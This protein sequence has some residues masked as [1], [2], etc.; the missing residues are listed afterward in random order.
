MIAESAFE[1]HEHQERAPDLRPS[2]DCGGPGSTRRN[3]ATG[4]VTEHVPEPQESRSV[5]GQISGHH[6]PTTSRCTATVL[7]IDLA[8]A[9][10]HPPPGAAR[11]GRCS[12]TTAR[13]SASGART[14]VTLLLSYATSGRSVDRRATLSRGGHVCRPHQGRTSA[15]LERRGVAA[16]GGGLVWWAH[17]GVSWVMP[18][19]AFVVAIGVRGGECCAPGCSPVEGGEIATWPHSWPW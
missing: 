8:R 12:R 18:A 17:A 4:T 7:W 9:A 10:V 3:S 5:C 19:V 1:T 2:G 16:I 14:A 6:V 15:P 13:G 11:T